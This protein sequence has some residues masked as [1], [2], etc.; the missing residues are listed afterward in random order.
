MAEAV[1]QQTVCGMPVCSG[2]YLRQ[3]Q[4]L[5]VVNPVHVTGCLDRF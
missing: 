2:A 3:A 5:Q 4:G 1:D